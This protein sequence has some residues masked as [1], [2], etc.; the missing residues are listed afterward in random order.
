MQEILNLLN[1]MSPYLLLGFGIA[2]VMHT[3]V[4]N[5]MYNRY[6]SG[7]GLRSVLYAAA[8]GVPLPLCSCGVLPTAMSLRREGASKGA[9]TSFLIATPQTGIDSIAATYS[10]MGLPFAIIRPIAA[11]VTAL[12]GG[13]LVN[14]F[15]NNET[16]TDSSPSVKDTSAAHLTLKEKTLGALRYGYVDMMQDIGRWLVLGL[17]VAGI[18]TVAVPDGFFSSFSDRPFLGMLLVLACAIP[19]YLCATGSIPIAVALMLKGMTPGAALVLLMAGPAVNVASLLVIRKVLGT[20]TLWLYLTAIV[21]GAIAFALGIDYLLPREWFTDSLIPL[22][23]ACHTH[24]PW[25]NLICSAALLILLVYALISR[26]RKSQ[27]CCETTCNNS[28]CCDTATCSDTTCH[29]E[30]PTVQTLIVTGMQCNHCRASVIR[31]ISNL[32]GTESVDVDLASGH[33]IVTGTASLPAIVQAI[34]TLGF[35]VEK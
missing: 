35:G 15:D 10:L 23:E 2:G 16:I 28:N 32:P 12:F 27:S 9:T 4:P 34:E 8:L 22:Q 1:Q 6:L 20:H 19:M 7:H 31:A 17:V 29:K 33:V 5:Q 26:M 25:F 14:L 30:E 11:L 24:T 18:I 3:F 13:M 21:G